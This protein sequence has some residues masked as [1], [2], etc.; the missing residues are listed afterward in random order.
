MVTG[1]TK[2]QGREVLLAIFVLLA[3]LLATIG[4]VSYR[5]L[6]ETLHD[7]EIDRLHA[8]SDLKA[9]QVATWLGERLA[10]ARVL[11][12]RPTALSVLAE[13]DGM[14]GL[15]TR[16]SLEQMLH[17]YDYL[18]I[19]LF[20]VQGE[21]DA[22][23]G[24]PMSAT[25]ITPERMK[26]LARQRAP[27]LI[28]FYRTGNAEHPIGLAVATAIYDLA[29]ENGPAK[30][31][32]ILHIDPE[33]LLFNML[34]TWPL[35]SASAEVVLV[36]G[37]GERIL[38]LN[39]LRHSS[40]EPM[41]MRLPADHKLPATQALRGDDVGGDGK[42]YRGVE[43]LFGS[44]AVAGTPWRLV[45]K[46]DRDEVLSGLRWASVAVALAVLL[47]LI[48]AAKLLLTRS[49][50]QEIE[51]LRALSEQERYFHDVLDHSADAIVIVAEEGAIGYANLQAARL[52]DNRV[53]DLLKTTWDRLM[54]A[55]STAT[56]MDLARD[57]TEAGWLP[58]EIRIRTA[59]G[60]IIPVELTC[61]RLPDRR[62]CLAI[63]DVSERRALQDDLR[64][65]ESRFRD[66]SASSAD[67]FWETDAD[68]RFTWVSDNVED[69]AGLKVAEILGR[70]REE[71]LEL[72]ADKDVASWDS[73]NR[74]LRER[75]AFRNHEYCV[76]DRR[77]GVQWLSV[78]GVPYAGMDGAFAGYRG[79][80]QVITRRRESEEELSRYRTGLERLVQERT[81]ELEDARQRAETAT[82]AKS[83][84][85][86]N[87][88]HEIRT[89]MNAILGFVHLMRGENLTDTQSEKLSR[90]AFAAQHL[91]AVINDILD[92]SKIEAGKMVLERADF[93]LSPM[94]HKVVA[95]VAQSIQAKQV[96]LEVDVATLPARVNGDAT[97]LGQ[98]L[99]NYLS[100]A[101][102]FTESGTITLR[103]S[104]LEESA[105][106]YL[107]RLEV[108]DTGVGV[109]PDVLPRLFASF[110]QADASTTRRY[111]GTGLGLAITKALA[112]LMG[113]SV[114]AD[115]LQGQGST[116]WLTVRLGKATSASP[117]EPLIEQFEPAEVA[118]AREFAGSRILLAEDEPINQIIS[119]E[120][121]EGLGMVVSIASNGEQ[122]VSMVASQPF[123]LVLTDM[124]MPVLDGLDATR[125]IRRQ[126]GCADLPV[127]AMTAN[128]FAEDR[129]RCLEAGMN[130]FIAKP[131]DPEVLYATL[132]KWLRKGRAA[133]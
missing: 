72:P 65:S 50:Q 77:G 83:V 15:R 101:M 28:D 71:L 114:G 122:A 10:D 47:L 113:G 90:I 125:R 46:V 126:P 14:H 24:Q 94:L 80:G 119:Q 76:V 86:A 73:L 32:A 29:E 9:Q 91:L 36:R 40:V 92:I 107:V 34:Q 118:L 103:G 66:F 112:E 13:E 127:I 38:F 88:S 79:V 59:K 33:R 116:F 117:D 130:D 20:D 81:R 30:G 18:G 85:L 96:T 19:E 56:L 35:P 6:A 115:S 26:R 52:F 1:E 3:F 100:N 37:E 60:R 128:A 49:R 89:P 109:A 106:D 51:Q 97:R 121:L 129:L 93:E 44:S 2:A 4:W 12:G 108:I 67:W 64:L 74:M 111:G 87:M 123:D 16:R 82:L 78:S 68:H 98:A 110:E 63:R 102:K 124:Q 133:D 70:T 69:V 41:T 55:D 22:Q 27:E 104:V 84:F 5:T 95:I 17:A 8:I 23:A 39:R 54:P 45:A 99:L 61:A 53:D 62:W 7:R 120:L 75:Q 57:A 43:T 131:I 132:L 11:A 105:S 31:Y 25:L 48:L 42:D 58:R 21:R